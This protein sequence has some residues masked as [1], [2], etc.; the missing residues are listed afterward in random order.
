[1]ASEQN[2]LYTK[3]GTATGAHVALETAHP[4]KYDHWVIKNTQSSAGDTIEIKINGSAAI[5]LAGSESLSLDITASPEN[6]TVKENGHGYR[7]IGTGR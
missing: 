2:V 1:M 6:V 7:V 5:V 4:T 3:S